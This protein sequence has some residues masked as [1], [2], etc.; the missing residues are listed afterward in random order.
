MSGFPRLRK[1]G[2]A[3]MRKV[4]L[5]ARLMLQRMPG[6]QK[7]TN[8]FKTAINE[9][10]AIPGE[11]VRSFPAFEIEETGSHVTTKELQAPPPKQFRIAAVKTV[12]EKKLKQPSA[13]GKT[14]RRVVREVVVDNRTKEVLEKLTKMFEASQKTMA[15]V[16]A[17]RNKII[18]AL[19]SALQESD[20][21]IDRQMEV[22]NKIL[23]RLSTLA[24]KE[25]SDVQEEDYSEQGAMLQQIVNE[26]VQRNRTPDYA[27][28][29]R[30]VGE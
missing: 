17:D 16:F 22:H 21:R 28:L 3:G 1:D 13:A 11:R 6:R 9:G 25:G 24:K 19:A 20:D 23:E 26:T 12:S 8:F 15:Q 27:M 29:S 7:P 10:R 4:D 2:G 5:I 14:M 18:Q 30:I